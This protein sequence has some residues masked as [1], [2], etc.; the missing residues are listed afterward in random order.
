MISCVTVFMMFMTKY[1][2]ANCCWNAGKF[3]WFMTD[4]ESPL[5]GWFT[6]DRDFKMPD[7]NVYKKDTTIHFVTNQKQCRYVGTVVKS[8]QCK[9]DGAK[10]YYEEFISN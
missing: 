1:E 2:H 4:K 5:N 10:F 7:G 8:G 6:F 9:L 3:G